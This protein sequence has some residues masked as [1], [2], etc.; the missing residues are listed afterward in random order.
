M[1]TE[2]LEYNDLSPLVNFTNDNLQNV[3]IYNIY[4][5]LVKTISFIL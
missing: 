4:M 3:S 2:I 1:K 5:L